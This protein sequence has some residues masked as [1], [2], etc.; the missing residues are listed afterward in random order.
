M[1]I[2]VLMHYHHKEKTKATKSILLKQRRGAEI[3]ARVHLGMKGK[4][5]ILNY[6]EITF[7]KRDAK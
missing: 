4:A 1:S 5:H 6:P 3:D 2:I 7:Y